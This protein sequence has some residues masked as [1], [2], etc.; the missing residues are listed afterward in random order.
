M[1]ALASEILYPKY[2]S[3][4]LSLNRNYRSLRKFH[5]RLHSLSK[6]SVG[7]FCFCLSS[8]CQPRLLESILPVWNRTQA[9]AIRV[10]AFYRDGTSL[11]WL[12]TVVAFHCDGT[13]PWWHFTVMALHCGGTSLWWHFTVITLNCGGTS[14]WWHFTLVALHFGGTSL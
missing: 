14:L 12:F 8:H 11:W 10:A 1:D 9:F 7:L 13:S 3:I 2:A 5:R 6:C 4:S